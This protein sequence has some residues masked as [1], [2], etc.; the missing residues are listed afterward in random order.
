MT[1][2]AQ[3][4]LLVLNNMNHQEPKKRKSIKNKIEPPDYQFASSFED[5]AVPG[6]TLQTLLHHTQPCVKDLD[7]AKLHPHLINLV[8]AT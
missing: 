3:T 6:S 7:Y 1:R 5:I 8:W 2:R 4:H